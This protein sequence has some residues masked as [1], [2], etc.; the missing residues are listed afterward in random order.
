MQLETGKG[1]GRTAVAVTVET[2]KGRGR[3]AD[4]V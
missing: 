3:K 2:G 1:R 4:V